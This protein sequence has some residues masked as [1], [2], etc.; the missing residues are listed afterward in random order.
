MH[1]ISRCEDDVLLIYKYMSKH[2]TVQPLL[3]IDF[4]IESLE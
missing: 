3:C 2:S 4:H 1:L